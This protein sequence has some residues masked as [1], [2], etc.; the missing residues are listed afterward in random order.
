MIPDE[1]QPCDSDFPAPVAEYTDDDDDC[2]STADD[3]DW[4]I[5]DIE[6]RPHPNYVLDRYAN[7]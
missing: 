6:E 7:W 2:D 3:D 1:S 5:E 4:T